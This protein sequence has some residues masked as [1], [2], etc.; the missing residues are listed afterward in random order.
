MLEYFLESEMN[1]H[2]SY[3]KNSAEGNNSGNSRN[4]NFPKIVQ[5]E[6]GRAQ[7]RISRD[8]NGTFELIVDLI[9]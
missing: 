1:V 2:L 6:H 4:G 8:R 3:K 9:G 5:T 7:I